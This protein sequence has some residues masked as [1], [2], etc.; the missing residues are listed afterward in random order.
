VTIG[1]LRQATIVIS[2]INDAYLRRQ[3]IF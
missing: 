1:K 3:R 2:D